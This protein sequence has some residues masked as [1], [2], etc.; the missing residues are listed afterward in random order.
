MSFWKDVFAAVLANSSQGGN[1]L[2]VEPDNWVSIE[3]LH[4]AGTW[5][6]VSYSVNDSFAIA[7]ALEQAKRQYPDN[8]VRA[9]TK[10]GRLLDMMM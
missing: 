3:Y 2:K 9:V 8:R 4:E 10:E 6:G 7:N 5:F 1:G